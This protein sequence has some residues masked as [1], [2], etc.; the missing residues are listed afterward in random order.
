[1]TR[2]TPPG[3]PLVTWCHCAR[4]RSQA[5]RLAFSGSQAQP[6]AAAALAG[7]A[8]PSRATVTTA[9][10][11][12]GHCAHTSCV[13]I[14]AGSHRHHAAGSWHTAHS[15]KMNSITP[16]LEMCMSAGASNTLLF[17]ARMPSAGH[18]AVR[19]RARGGQQ[20]A[21]LAAAARAA[22][23]RDMRTVGAVPC[24]AHGWWQVAL[25][26]WPAARLYTARPTTRNFKRRTPLHAGLRSGRAA[27]AP[28]CSARAHFALD[29]IM[30][31]SWREALSRWRRPRVAPVRRVSACAER[32]G[33]AAMRP[34]AMA[35]VVCQAREGGCILCALAAHWRRG[36]VPLQCR[37]TR[38]TRR[39]RSA[40]T[41]W[42]PD[43]PRGA[44]RAAA[45][46]ERVIP[47]VHAG[48]PRHALG[49]C[50]LSGQC[51][52]DS[53]HTAAASG[54]RAVVRAGCGRRCRCPQR[55][56]QRAAAVLQRPRGHAI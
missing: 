29:R 32:R 30:R 4:A 38:G 13:A 50:T 47:A 10:A 9:A 26:R 22:R 25:V 20:R 45:E 42:P 36:R 55:A 21:A 54:M 39:S 1:L 27:E 52:I 11:P 17:A 14:A 43:G 12:H 51:A 35:A 31:V 33:T 16:V 15:A 41:R 46:S 34:S 2:G 49:A 56:A 19:P 6:E 5:L 18:A 8:G 48:H 23:R 40:A 53:G 24:S 3:T 44:A 28:L 37:S 7:G